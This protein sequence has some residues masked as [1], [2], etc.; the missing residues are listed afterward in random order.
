MSAWFLSAFSIGLLSSF[1][2]IGMC[3]PLALALPVKQLSPGHRWLALLTYH[4]SRIATYT[5]A[6]LVFGLLGHSIWLAGF[7]QLF[8]ISLG[9]LILVIVWT[10]RLHRQPAFFKRAFAVLRS[11][12]SRLWLS[13]SR[14]KF[15]LM[16]MANGLLPCGMVYLAIAGAVSS[17]HISDAMLFMFFFGAGTLPLLLALSSYSQLISLSFRMR[18]KKAIPFF[19]AA[20]GLL[21]ILRGLGLGL[22]FI[23]PVLSAHSGHAILCH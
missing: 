9:V 2:C 3:G 12:I 1:H 15:A 21:L 19:I 17:P 20:M 13:P 10:G 5:A 22:P 18:I 11:F 23:S 14:A 4:L 16:G 7:Q 8:S 6:G